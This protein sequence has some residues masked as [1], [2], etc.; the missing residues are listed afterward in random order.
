MGSSIVTMCFLKFALMC[1]IIA[2]S[3]VDLPLPVEPATNTMPRGDSAIF[4]IASFKPSSWKLGT[5]VLTKRIARQKLP[6][7]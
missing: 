4:L 7:C 6:R 2:A 5:V 1:S 3:V